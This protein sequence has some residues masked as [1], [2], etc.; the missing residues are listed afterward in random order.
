MDERRSCGLLLHITSLPS[1]GGN[2]D[3]G[4]EAYSFVD[5]LKKSGQKI[6]QVLPLNAVSPEY[7][8]SPY[9]PVSVFAL[10]PLLL[11]PEKMLKSGWI[12]S[13]PTF[14]RNKEDTNAHFNRS[15]Q[16]R[17]ACIQYTVINNKQKILNNPHY[18][19]FKQQNEHWLPDFALF[20]ALK[21]YFGRNN[22]WT[23]WPLELMRR[24]RKA[25]LKWEKKLREKILEHK[26]AQFIVQK[27]WEELKAY[28]NRQGM[29]I[30]GD[31]PFY[32]ALESSDLWA[33]QY[34]FRVD[35]KGKPLFLSGA[36]PD[37]FSST[38]QFWD[39][40][41]Y[42][43]PRHQKDDFYW[44]KERIKKNM[45]L[46]DLL[47]LDHFR[48]FCSYWEIPAEEKTAA[49]GK[50]A[51]SPGEDF[52]AE[53]MGR[54]RS[55]RFIVEDLGEITPDVLGL[56]EKYDLPGMHVLQFAFGED[57]GKNPHIVHNHGINGVVYTGT[58]DNNTLLGWYKN[59][60]TPEGRKRL[61]NYLGIKVN[62]DN[63]SSHM[64]RLA[65]SSVAKTCII[66]V[67]DILQLDESARMNTPGGSGNN[68]VW[69]LQT[70]QLKNN[71]AENLKNICATY[72]RI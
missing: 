67:Q 29:C 23:E 39:T 59:E 16:F 22:S 45:R 36:P 68:W 52:M 46:F 33:N 6:W 8:F 35:E 40:P 56:K 28:A 20:Q 11:S 25:L 18:Q 10:N 58:H 17:Y 24:D 70:E 27:Q 12:D 9:S 31:L 26:F 21:D 61:R 5:F 48:G 1:L 54:F 3:L 62:K 63:L 57:M 72:G 14:E 2:G 15:A 44:W 64:L 66:P 71:C 55:R 50:W 60:L 42:Y 7:S 49:S 4:P 32:P 38:G 41:V 69:R 43:W 13:L 65:M 51:P 34:L 53:L 37:Y 30:M 47:R 19:K